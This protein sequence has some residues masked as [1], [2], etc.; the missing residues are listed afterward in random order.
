[1]SQPRLVHQRRRRRL[2][3]IVV[4]LHQMQQLSGGIVVRAES[5]GAVARP[6]F[7]VQLVVVLLAVADALVHF[8]HRVIKHRLTDAAG[9]HVVQHGLRV[10][11]CGLLNERFEAACTKISFGGIK[12]P[13]VV[14]SA[15]SD[16]D[17]PQHSLFTWNIAVFDHPR[18]PRKSG[19]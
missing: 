7:L 14:V 4:T 12:L 18:S 1:M 17:S 9:L 2:L 11:S 8:A 16:R 13:G 10:G 3:A 5:G 6:A 15:G 19:W